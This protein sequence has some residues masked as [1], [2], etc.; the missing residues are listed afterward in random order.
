MYY[1]VDS[2]K[3]S[4]YVMFWEEKKNPEGKDF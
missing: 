2:E 1:L 4:F 3:K